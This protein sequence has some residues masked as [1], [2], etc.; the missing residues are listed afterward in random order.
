MRE[1]PERL[2]SSDF[3]PHSYLDMEATITHCTKILGIWNWA[4]QRPGDGARLG[5]GELRRRA[6]AD[7]F[8]RHRP[9]AEAPRDMAPAGK[10][11]A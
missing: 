6:D 2:F 3:M 11:P 1:F 4:R 10:V 8:G 9:A 7:V 5:T